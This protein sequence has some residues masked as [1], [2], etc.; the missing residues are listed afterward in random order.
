M[1]Q[2]DLC[3]RCLN[4]KA[5]NT[6]DDTKMKI[7]ARHI[8]IAIASQFNYRQNLIVPN[9]SWG[10]GLSYEADLVVVSPARYATEI[11]IKVS[12]SDLKKDR[13][14]RKHLFRDSEYYGN[15][16]FKF[17]YFAIPQEMFD[18]HKDEIYTFI[19]EDAGLLIA[20]PS[21][22]NREF[23]LVVNTEKPPKINKRANKLSD[24]DYLNLC[25]LGTMR[26]WDLKKHLIRN[27]RENKK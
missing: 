24:K 21:G 4:E 18:K 6:T 12:F 1:L 19:P 27:E 15:N 26:I 7:T 17:Y 23:D 9:V 14:K 10:W 5:N 8:E 25:R 3:Q 2:Y 13:E 11:E 16:K 22:F 20:K